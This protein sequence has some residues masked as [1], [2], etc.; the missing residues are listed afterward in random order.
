MRERS[1]AEKAGTHAY[2]L[3]ATA[4]PLHSERTVC[5]SEERSAARTRPAGP[6]I[7]A[8]RPCADA[9]TAAGQRIQAIIPQATLTRSNLSRRA[10]KE[11]LALQWTI[12]PPA[13]AVISPVKDRG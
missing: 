4:T 11:T 12:P 9:S 7:A 5:A 2:T 10:R 6:E 1:V 3:L 8:P 13:R